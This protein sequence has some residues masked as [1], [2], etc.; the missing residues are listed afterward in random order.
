MAY[1]GI[2]DKS[3]LIHHTICVVG[4]SLSVIT[5]LSA[6]FLIAAL[7]V[8]EISNPAMHIRVVLKHLGKRYTKAYETAELSYISK[9]KDFFISYK[10]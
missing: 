8:S 9:K 4:M 2:L 1:L 7:F 6:N 10:I 5:G 3:M